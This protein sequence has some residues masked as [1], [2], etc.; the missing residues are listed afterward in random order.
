MTGVALDRPLTSGPKGSTSCPRTSIARS[1][2][3][4][5]PAG[6]P[7]E[8]NFDLVEAPIPEPGR[9]KFLARTIYLSLDPYMRG[10]MSDRASYANPAEVGKPMVG[11]TVGQVVRSNHPD[12]A[13][14]DY[15][16]GYGM[17][18]VWTLRRHGGAQARPEDWPALVMRWGCSAC[19]A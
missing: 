18:R 14:G 3:R 1:C 16:L 7:S 2:L 6:E 8:D 19:P 17:A 11:G 12:Y 5:A 10:R 15:V 4:A 13:E 9:G